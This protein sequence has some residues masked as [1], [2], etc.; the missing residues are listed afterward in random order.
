MQL[1]LKEIAPP[2]HRRPRCPLLRIYPRPLLFYVCSS[3]ACVL[4]LGRLGSVV[5]QDGQQKQQHR[6]AMKECAKGVLRLAY[7]AQEV[8]RGQWSKAQSAARRALK[9]RLSLNP[10]ARAT[11]A[12]ALAPSPS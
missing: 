5:G 8:G 7:D 1:Q 9:Q 3:F 10:G 6:G 11:L 4:G 12:L 2:H